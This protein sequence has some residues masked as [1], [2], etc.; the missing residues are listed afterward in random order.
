MSN[1]NYNSKERERISLLFVTVVLCLGFLTLY[2]NHNK[3]KKQFAAANDGYKEKS[4]LNLQKD[5]NTKDLADLFVTG[6]YVSDPK[7]AEL[8]AEHIK[9][10]LE[11]GAELPNLGELNKKTFRISVALTD[12][13]GGTGLKARIKRSREILGIDGEVMKKYAEN[14]P[15]A[16]DLNNGDC[17]IKV[18]V[19]QIDSTANR[20]VRML[21]RNYKP[22]SSVMV[23]L[24]EHY[25][26]TAFAENGKDSVKMAADSIVGYAI[27]DKKGFATFS[28]LNKDGFYSVLPIKY[29]FEY[30]I[31]RGTTKGGLGGN[32]EFTF[33]QRQHQI[34]PFDALAYSQIKEDNALTVRTPEQYKDDLITHLT[35]FLL[36][37]WAL[38]FYLSVRNR[39]R[40]IET[41]NLLLPVLMTLSGICLLAMYAII[42]PLSDR[43]IGNKMAVGAIAGVVLI[44]VMSE[45]DFVKFFN[46]QYQWFGFLKRFKAFT[47]VIY[48]SM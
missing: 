48:S 42:N 15:Q 32:R 28:G 16:L 40:K 30:G 31:S 43:M 1:R 9:H 14:I 29:G 18:K 6:N 35:F 41:D 3:P 12:S 37:W 20:L 26:I 34:T 25:Y 13:L 33:T 23:R 44:G 5:F 2:N 7:D 11:N 24:R 19:Q 8:I 4:V 47:L 46:S 39:R 27:T 45:I 21:D 36:A 22:A 17:E 38:H 10:K